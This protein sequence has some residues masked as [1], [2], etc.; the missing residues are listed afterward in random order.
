MMTNGWHE[1]AIAWSMKSLS[2]GFTLQAILM[3]WIV[4]QY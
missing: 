3:L 2:G 4:S 1:H